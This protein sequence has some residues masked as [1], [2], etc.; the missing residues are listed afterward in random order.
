[1]VA[2][3]ANKFNKTMQIWPTDHPHAPFEEFSIDFTTD[4]DL[5]YDGY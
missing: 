1:M 5:E 2:Q 4:M 3:L